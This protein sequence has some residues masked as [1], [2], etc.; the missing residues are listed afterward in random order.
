MREDANH[1]GAASGLTARRLSFLGMF[2]LALA[3]LP[4]TGCGNVGADLVDQ[5]CKCEGCGQRA[6]QEYETKV[7]SEINVAEIYNCYNL[8]EPYYQ[9]QIQEHNCLDHKYSANDTDS[10][11]KHELDQYMQCLKGQSS[12]DPG[13][14]EG[15]PSP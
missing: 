12:R 1:K 14:Y 13:P 7:E 3:S 11:C 4:L 2:A 10:G 9:C 15:Q 8:L 5:I 6:R